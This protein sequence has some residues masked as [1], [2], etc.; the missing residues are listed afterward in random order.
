MKKSIEIIWENF[1]TENILNYINSF[2]ENPLA[3]VV[4][5]DGIKYMSQGAF[6]NYFKDWY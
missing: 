5:N 4:V 2:N 3:E 1:Y 6:S